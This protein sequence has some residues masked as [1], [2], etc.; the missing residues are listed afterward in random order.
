MVLNLY[1]FI[2]FLSCLFVCC[3]SQVY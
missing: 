3:A 1:K 2:T